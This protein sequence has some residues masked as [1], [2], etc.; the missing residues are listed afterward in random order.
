MNNPTKI[1]VSQSKPNKSP[2]RRSKMSRRMPIRERGRSNPTG[3]S[4]ETF[5]WPERIS[6]INAR[7]WN[8][9]VVHRRG[10]D[11]I[12]AQAIGAVRLTISH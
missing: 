4:K 9:S 6:I 5:K 8:V 3:L 1:N 11:P 10:R 2:R 12:V 7:T